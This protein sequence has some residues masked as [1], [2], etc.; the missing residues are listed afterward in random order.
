MTEPPRPISI[1]QPRRVD[2]ELAWV[3]P[4]PGPF[5][6]HHAARRVL[7]PRKGPL[8][9]R[10]CL[11]GE[12]V[13]AGYLYAPHLTP[14]EVLAAQLRE[15]A[16]A[17][18]YEVI[19]L[20]RTN[21]TLAGLAATVEAALQLEPDSLV[22]FAGNNWGLL[23][24]PEVSPYAPSVPARRDF[25]AA[26][27]QA[28]PAG[29]VGLA[30]RR[31][32]GRVHRTLDRIAGLAGRAGAAVVTLL[33]EVNLADWE[34]RQP[35]VWLPGEG[36]ERWYGLLEKALAA[37]GRG[38]PAAAEEAAWRMN[39]LDG[40][41]GPVPF[42][43]LARA[44]T[45]QGREAEARDAA[46]AEVDSVHYPLL[47]FLGAPQATTAARELLADAAERH[48]W[49]A[50]DVRTVLTA[51]TGS[52]FPGRRQFLD[53]CHLT[54]EGMHGAMAAVTAA[55]LGL[56]PVAGGPWEAEGLELARRLPPPEI[57]PE[58]E[59]T[60]RLGAALHGAHRLLPVGGPPG[61]G[62]PVVDHWC[63]AALEASPGAAA[64]MLDLARARLASLPAVLTGAGRRIL[65]SPYRLGLQH[66]LKWDG[67]DG[68]VLL[69][70]ASALRGAGLPEAEELSEA[71]RAAGA[72]P[73][74]GL[75]LAHGVRYLAEPLARPYPEV[76]DLPYLTGRAPLRCPWPETSFWLPLRDPSPVV[77]RL[78]AR[79]PPIPIP[80]GV[81]AY[82][83]G[84]A[85]LRVNGEDA[86]ELPLAESWTRA[87]LR[88][89]A[90]ALRPGL[91][92]VTLR[93]PMPPPVG[94]HALEAARCRLARGL[95][96]DLHPI[97][98]EVFSL[99]A[100]PA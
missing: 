27:G 66:G 22:L 89:P 65:G 10:I 94:E 33:P 84:R 77:L 41:T 75:E 82:R 17:G 32:D 14:A 91:N 99:R 44:W 47:C 16:G 46:L 80:E 73:P 39:A 29:A 8:P 87:A 1:W 25:A 38:D 23:E 61:A 72:L 2:G 20:A 43:L 96:A 70:M 24:T 79:L 36:T 53:Y 63:R 93:W 56:R 58:A 57:S 86:A 21:E 5:G 68:E 52:V 6:D 7:R 45:A 28:G 11:F 15:V 62:A 19:D 100:H 4:E 54:A 83:R 59:A 18:A 74:E 48:G 31:L 12:S 92:L 90:A 3:R 13:A 81:E 37:L 71:L 30:R 97:F 50:V 40:S 64:A 76:M 35:P 78:T 42:R 60:A 95:E 69:A 34:G 67:L 85:A 51:W 9:R 98:G 88:V 55:V 49:A 26:L